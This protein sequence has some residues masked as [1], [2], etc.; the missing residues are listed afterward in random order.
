M[1]FRNLVLV[2]F[3][4]RLAPTTKRDHNASTWDWKTKSWL[5][6]GNSNQMLYSRTGWSAPVNSETAEIVNADSVEL[7]SDD[8]PWTKIVWIKSEL[9]PTFIT[10]LR[11]LAEILKIH[12]DKPWH[13]FNFWIWHPSQ[14]WKWEWRGVWWDKGF[15]KC[16]CRPILGHLHF[17]IWTLPAIK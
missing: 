12:L 3:N 6:N 4:K 11:I 8:G 1:T 7:L 17:T 5:W 14:R 15:Q 9:S 10:I 2:T 13:L 16:H